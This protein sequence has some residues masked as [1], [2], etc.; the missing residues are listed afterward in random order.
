MIYTALFSLIK[1]P[2][3]IFSNLPISKTIQLLNKENYYFNFIMM[4][5]SIYASSCSKLCCYVQ[6]QVGVIDL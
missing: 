3:N 4:I 2:H 1:N 6:S 5:L